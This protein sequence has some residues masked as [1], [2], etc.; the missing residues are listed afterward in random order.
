MR[1][2]EQH[3]VITTVA[4]TP[5]QMKLI[6]ANQ[7]LFLSIY[8][9]QMKLMLLSQAKTNDLLLMLIEA[10]GEGEGEDDC[11]PGT[12]LDGRPMR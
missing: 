11:S 10:M 6:L 4:L 2:P 5:D 12:Y 9:E 8:Q 7:E 3:S 1:E